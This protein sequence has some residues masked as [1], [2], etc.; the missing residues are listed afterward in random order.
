MTYAKGRGVRIEI[1]KTYGAA[2]PVTEV[3]AAEPPVVTTA[4]A[5]GLA[6]KTWGYFSVATGMP[7]LEGQACR[8]ATASGSTFA[9]EDLDST[10]YGDFSAGQ[11]IPVTEWAVLGS[12]TSYDKSGGEAEDDDVSVLLDNI[13][14]V[15]AGQ[16]SAEQMSIS[17]RTLTIADEA[18]RIVR[19]AARNNDYI[20]LRVVLKDGN[21]R[22][23]RGQPGMPNESMNVGTTGTTT[24]NLKCKGFWIEGA[25]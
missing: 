7:T 18:L 2:K 5:H 24:F 10:A 9:L 14:Q 17:L 1:A 21:V 23:V 19:K 12:A 6:A 3:T 13:K 25:A 11:F 20:L 15:E 22:G 4:T 16:L 8:L